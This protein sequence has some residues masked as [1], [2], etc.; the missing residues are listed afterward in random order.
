MRIPN[1]E[2]YIEVIG[3]GQFLEV[4]TR[5]VAEVLLEVRASLENNHARS[6]LK[7]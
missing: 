4:A 1:V 7:P 3:E 5:F 2:R 6:L